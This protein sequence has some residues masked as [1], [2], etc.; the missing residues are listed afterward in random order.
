MLWDDKGWKQTE[1][2][3]PERRFRR[4]CFSS[5]Y[6]RFSMT[7]SAALQY[8]TRLWIE[9]NPFQTSQSTPRH[10]RSKWAIEASGR[11]CKQPSSWLWKCASKVL[12]RTDT[13]DFV[14]DDWKKAGCHRWQSRVRS[15]HSIR[16]S[17]CA[18]LVFKSR[19]FVTSCFSQHWYS[20]NI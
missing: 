7:L 20:A 5:S 13:D 19:I 8:R 4:R 16:L 1:A 12:A 17:F 10:T 11:P 9:V 15:H 6:P 3:V 18:P 2:P 14:A